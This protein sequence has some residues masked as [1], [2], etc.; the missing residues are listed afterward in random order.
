[1]TIHELN[2]VFRKHFGFNAPIDMMMTQLKGPRFAV[3]DTVKL[4]EEFGRRDPD[5]DPEKCTYK[6]K[7]DIS[8]SEYIFLKYGQKA[9][10]FIKNQM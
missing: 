9:H 10:D 7:K 3:I 1:M 8:I 5:Y 4:D 6:D 2:K